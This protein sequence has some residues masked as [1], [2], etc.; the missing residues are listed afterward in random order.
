MAVASTMGGIALANSKLGTVHGYAGVLGGMF[1]VAPHGALCA[2]LLP[3]VFRKNA[4]KLSQVVDGEVSEAEAG[5]SVQMARVRLQRIIEV[6]RLLTNNNNATYMDGCAWLDAMVKDLQVPGL[7]KLCGMQMEHVDECVD[8]TAGAS[9][10][11]GNPILWDKQ[12]LR[13]VLL[14]AM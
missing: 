10:T 2:A 3:H 4:R 9:S 7:T 1:E 6:S 8:A 13:E 5:L 14:A 12:E 11:K